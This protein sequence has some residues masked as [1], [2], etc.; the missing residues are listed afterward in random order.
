[1]ARD[2]SIGTGERGCEQFSERPAMLNRPGQRN[3]SFGRRRPLSKSASKLKGFT[4]EPGGKAMRWAAG[5]PWAATNWRSR[6]RSSKAMP[7][8]L[9]SPEAY[10]DGKSRNPETLVQNSRRRQNFREP[11]DTLS[12]SKPIVGL[13]A[14]S[15][16]LVHCTICHHFAMALRRGSPVVYPVRP[17]ASSACQ[18]EAI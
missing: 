11:T 2:T 9:S 13:H 8:R 16:G 1:M 3:W 18:P 7:A 4:A 6:R 17:C 5:R 10:S 14:T 15:H 12:D